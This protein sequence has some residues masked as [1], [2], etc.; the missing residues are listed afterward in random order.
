MT[1]VKPIPTLHRRRI[2][3][4]LQ[5]SQEQKAQ[6]QAERKNFHQRCKEV[7][8]RIQPELIKNHYNWYIVVEPDSGD[9]ISDRNKEVA[10]QMAHH[11]YPNIVP[12][13]L[14]RIN[15]TG[16]SGTI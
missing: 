13:F 4:E 12:L 8:D 3:P 2:F 16:I 6:R 9:Y 1:E 10:M 7:F 11:K 5:W 15:E 14:F